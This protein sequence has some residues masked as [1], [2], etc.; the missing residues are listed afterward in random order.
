MKTELS[1]WHE[2]DR[3]TRERLTAAQRAALDQRPHWDLEPPQR[4]EYDTPRAY[5]DA[6]RQYADRVISGR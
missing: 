5:V 4:E 3:L 6:L 2:C 1:D